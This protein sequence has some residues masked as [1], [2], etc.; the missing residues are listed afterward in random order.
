MF[1]DI[2]GRGPEVLAAKKQLTVLHPS[3]PMGPAMTKTC[4]H[5][6]GQR[7]RHMCSVAMEDQYKTAH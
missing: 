7:S 3:R 4:Q 5:L 2:L 1:A 6:A